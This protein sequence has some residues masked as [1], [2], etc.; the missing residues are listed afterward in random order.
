MIRTRRAH[1][2]IDMGVI[3]KIVVAPDSFKGSI[4]ARDLCAALRKGI[5]AAMPDAQVIELPLAD[6]G[7]GTMENMVYA[8]GGTVCEVQASDP[9]GRPINA[10]YGVLGDNETVVIEMAQ[11]SGLPLLLAVERNPW[12]TTSFGTGQLLQHALDAGY[13]R[14]IIGLGGSATNDGGVGMLQAVGVRFYDQEG[15]LLPDGAGGGA[16]AELGS[17]DRS[18]LDDRLKE[19]TITIASDV[20]IPLCGPSGASA[21]F[22]P[23]KGATPGMVSQLDQALRRYGDVIFAELGVD[24]RDRPGSGAAGGMGAALMAFL[25]AESKSGIELVMETIGFAKKA[26][27]A[28]LIVTGEGRLDVQTLSGKVI[29]GVC[30]QASKL[31]V[32]TIALCGGME[33]TSSQMDVLGLAAAFTIVPKPCDL[34]EAMA[35]AAQWAS[36]RAEQI[37]RLLL[38]RR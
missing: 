27:D 3:M 17:L 11:A 8:T 10:A 21:V 15:R 5:L 19:S 18:R 38:L 28:D 24:V 22:G 35:H 36:E 16:L 31:Q 23:Q 2:R 6:G 34:D 25:E 33:L 13:R 7:E 32:P 20:A 37:M 9:L 26:G 1:W 4:A 30:A 29:A 12:I 14:F